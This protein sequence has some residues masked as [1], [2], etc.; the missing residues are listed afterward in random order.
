MRRYITWSTV[1]HC[2]VF[3]IVVLVTWLEPYRRPVKPKPI[4]IVR[5]APPQPPA[6]K[7]AQPTGKPPTPKPTVQTPKPTVQTPKPTVATP[8]P[9]ATKKVIAK[10]TPKT[11]PS[12]TPARTPTPTPWEPP[13]RPEDRLP[14]PKPTPKPTPTP[15]TPPVPPEARS[16]ASTPAPNRAAQPTPSGPTMIQGDAGQLDEWYLAKARERIQGYFNLPER[17]RRAGT[18][19]EVAFVVARDGAISQIELIRSTGD[20]TLDELAIKALR[21]TEQLLPLPDTLTKPYLRL[22]V[23]FDFAQEGA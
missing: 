1:L 20:R 11:T 5:P 14:K 12:P 10:E 17:Y 7:Q 22:T 4:Q 16:G 18:T 15:W 3:A 21:D 9:T 13:V 6:A 23:T 2:L 19:C 8:K